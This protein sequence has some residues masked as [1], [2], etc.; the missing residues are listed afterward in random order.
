MRVSGRRAFLAAAAYPLAARAQCRLEPSAF[1]RLRA[2]EG[3]PVVDA[4]VNGTPVTFLLD[5]GAQAHLVVPDAA[6]EL[7]LQLL[8]GTMPLIGTGGARAAPIVALAGVSLG[9]VQLDPAPTPVAPLPPSVPHMTPM[10]AGLLGAS[11]LDRFDLLLD[12]QAGQLGLYDAAG[13]GGAL[14]SLAPRM[15][16]IGLAITPDRQA[17]LPVQINGQVVTALLDT[18]SRATLLTADAARRLGLSAPESAN[19]ARGVDGERLPVGHTRVRELAVGDD[20]RRN[21]PISISPLQLGQADM[22]LGFDYLRQRRVWISYVTARLVIA[23]P[24]P[25]P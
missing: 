21:V 11:L 25:A 15:T 12:V 3:F 19:D 8:P 13:C 20:L 16:A 23:L 2:I 24:G 6:A 22:L 10:L 17:L 5:T 7:R 4:A 9:V 14:P 1:V 18:G